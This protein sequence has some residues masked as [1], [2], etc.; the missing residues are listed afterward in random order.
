M[1][2]CFQSITELTEMVKTMKNYG[3]LKQRAEV[4]SKLIE[5]SRYYLK[6]QFK[7]KVELHSN[8]ASHCASF[9]CSSPD[10]KIMFTAL[11]DDDH[12]DLCVHCNAIEEMFQLLNG[13]IESL[14]ELPNEKRKEFEFILKNA[15]ENV[16]NHK[17]HII[18]TFIQTYDWSHKMDQQYGPEI[19]FV[20][21][22]WGMKL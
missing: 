8:I 7:H 1:D 16:M 10:G 19:A 4:L 17:K 14:R 6:T 18:R 21:C 22:D 11:C 2:D 12:E 3:L 5:N 13:S 9:A 15:Y 20:T